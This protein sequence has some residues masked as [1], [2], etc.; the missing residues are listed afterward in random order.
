MNKLFFIAL[1]LLPSVVK[2]Q[3]FVDIAPSEG[4]FHSLN[5]NLQ[6]GG[7]G[8]C[9]FDF[10][11][12][13]WDDITFVQE[14]D[15]LLFYKN[16][17]GSFQLLPSLAYGN[18]QT[19]QLLW[20]DYDNDGDNDLF[21]TETNGKVRL[22]QNDGF[23]HFTD[24]SAQAGLSP[25]STN[26]FGVSFADYDND[27]HLDFYLA[28]YMMTGNLNDPTHQNALYR[29]NG[30]GTFTD[31]T[32]STGVGNGIQPSFMG[33]WMDVN[34]DHLPD[35]YVINDRVLWGNSLYLNNGDGTFTDYTNQ[36]GAE[37]FGEDPMSATFNDFD[38]DGDLDILCAN[39]GVPTK[40]I[41]LYVNNGDSTFT[42]N[43]G[44]LG[45]N[46]DV[47]FHCT[48]G[49][50]WL[51]F[52]NDTYQDLYITTGLLTL[53][54]SNEIRSYLFRSNAYQSFSDMQGL[55]NS[56]HVAASYAV[57]KGDINNDGFADLVVQNAKNFNSFIWKNNPGPSSNNHYLKITLEGV[58]A[59]KMAIGSWIKVYCDGNTYTHYT[60]CGENFVSQDSQHHIF[61]M[62][63]CE[64]VDSI[65]VEYQ[66]G[67]VDHYYKLLTNNH[68]YFLE[69]E[70]LSNEIAPPSSSLACIGDTIFLDAGNYETYSWN[71]GYQ[72]RFLPVTTS[73]S[74]FVTTT[75][76]SGMIVVSDTINLSFIDPPIILE[77]KTNVSC[78]GLTDGQT[79]LNVDT[80]ANSFWIQ[81]SNG[82]SGVLLSNVT[83]GNYSYFY[84]DNAGCSASGQA[85]ILEPEEIIIFT[86]ITSNQS[87]GGYDLDVLVFGGMSPF[88]YLLN[89]DVVSFP[90]AGLSSGIFT[91]D[92]ID[93]NGCS[94][95][96]TVVVGQ[97]SLIDLEFSQNSWFPNPNHTGQFAHT[98]SVQ[99][100]VLSVI[101]HIG[102][103][104]PFEVQ[105][106]SL[107]LKHQSG[108]YY[109]LFLEN[110]QRRYSK[111]I[112]H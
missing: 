31:V 81:W 110:N 95:S 111:V 91:L 17:N 52:N 88:T 14:N 33:V 76:L 77:T 11:N 16:V 35:L 83:E 5:T 105:D 85:L 108:V 29:N 42:E 74:Y 70:T 23:F 8:V 37:M 102:R 45:I 53:D 109:I 112:I 98:S 66:S 106:N 107:T 1:I 21:I 104:I 78:F 18:D 89:G 39:G 86:N 7:S 2:S 40:P 87:I 57:A 61:G 46:V 62:G 84:S 3:S 27:G 103:T 48:W 6:Y 65:I 60:R 75:I 28:R 4:I 25:F 93:N 26:N 72:D 32:I 24:V 68:Y 92:V 54:P 90:V 67:T 15:S 30:D 79:L 50:T 69:G 101:D 22:L 43:A 51:D 73:G 19:R 58:V 80:D 38:N 63:A 20:V 49:A 34:N 55:F 47:T 99:I 71:T 12:D 10:D 36:S 9:F 41:R 94:K 44:P 13:G 64:K 82:Q 59:N 100:D 56:N 97:T 96:D